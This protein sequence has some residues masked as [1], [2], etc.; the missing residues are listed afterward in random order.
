MEDAMYQEEIQAPSGGFVMGLICGAALG[1][2]AALMF[3]PFAG[4]EARE[5]IAS[6]AQRFKEKTSDAY[7]RVTKK[8]DDTMKKAG[9]VY[10]DANETLG[11]GEPLRPDYR[12]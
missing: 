9:Q 4:S 6:Q 8:V 5:R 12:S 2:T 7:D 3:A 11:R 10:A 1:V